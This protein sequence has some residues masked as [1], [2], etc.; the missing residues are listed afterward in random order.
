LCPELGGRSVV[1]GVVGSV[2]VEVSDPAAEGGSWVLEGAEVVQPGALFF[3]AF[4]ETLDHLVLLGSV[5]GDE[6]LAEAIV[7]TGGADATALDATEIGGARRGGPTS[8]RGALPVSLVRRRWLSW[9]RRSVWGAQMESSPDPHPGLPRCRPAVAQA[10]ATARRVPEV[11]QW[12]GSTT[13]VVQR[14]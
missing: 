5:G 12:L 4:E 6:L 9:R 10:G 1:E 2:F 3:E 13:V 11:S 8:R 7:S 14:N